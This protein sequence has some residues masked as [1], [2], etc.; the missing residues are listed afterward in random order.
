M[1]K[2][3]KSI[4]LGS[5]GTTTGEN[6]GTIL[7]DKSFIYRRL[8]NKLIENKKNEELEAITA[9]QRQLVAQVEK[10]LLEISALIFRSMNITNNVEESKKNNKPSTSK[11]MNFRLSDTSS[12]GD[13]KPIQK[14]NIANL[15][16]QRL[17]EEKSVFLGHLH[18][19]ETETS[20]LLRQTLNIAKQKSN[21]YFSIAAKKRR[22]LTILQNKRNL[23]TRAQTRELIK[24]NNFLQLQ[25]KPR[26]QALLDLDIHS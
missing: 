24:I 17:F 9:T 12:I 19:K 3:S 15:P 20:S 11:N 13:L 23:L 5:T 18:K 26:L 14:P 7:T 4:D 10:S 25:I 8:A 6:V 21:L 2:I 1:P 22:I 16:N